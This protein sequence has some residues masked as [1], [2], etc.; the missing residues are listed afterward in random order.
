MKE[1]Y[2]C[3]R[4]CGA[5]RFCGKGAEIKAARAALHY[6]E[7]PCI[8]GTSGSGAVF[9]SGCALRCVYCQNEKIRDGVTGKNISTE[10]LADIF[11]ELQDKGAN[12]INLVTAGHYE[13]QVAEALR[14]AKS[15]GLCVPVIY[16]TS[17]YEK[18]EAIRELEG[19]IDVYLPDLKYV[20]SRLSADYSKAP[21]YFKV[22]SEAIREMVRQTGRPEFYVKKKAT[23]D[24]Q[25]SLW[26]SESLLDAAE[27]NECA[28]ELMDEG[29]E[30]LIRRGTIVRHLLLPGCSGDSMAVI[31]YLYETYGDDIY[32]SIMNQYTP[33]PQVKDHPLLSHRVTQEEYDSVLDYAIGLGIENAFMQEGGVAEESF[34]PE[35]DC[36]GV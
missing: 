5:G 29:K 32:I 22:A 14:D 6:W 33:M 9:F 1:C 3:P 20:S 8:S 31:K 13:P 26:E 28:D 4:N 21:D 36:E 27:Y 12:N 16:N 17:S 23:L 11:L 35:F 10:R 19:L 34:I 7:E 24:R 15:R 30:V 25:L 2:L 18:A